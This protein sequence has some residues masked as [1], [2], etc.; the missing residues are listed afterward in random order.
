MA[1]LSLKYGVFPQI[2]PTVPPPTQ[3]SNGGHRQCLCSYFVQGP[4]QDLTLGMPRRGGHHPW[5]LFSDSNCMAARLVFVQIFSRPVSECDNARGFS[6]I[7]FSRKF[8]SL[9]ILKVQRDSRF[10]FFFGRNKIPSRVPDYPSG[11]QCAVGSVF[12][13]D[14]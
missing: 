4:R 3:A 10:F 1:C 9:L 7:F 5:V 8:V 12:F 2:N 14:S 11:Q 6:D 13:L